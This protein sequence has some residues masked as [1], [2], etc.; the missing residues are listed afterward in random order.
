MVS[1]ETVTHKKTASIAVAGN[2]NCG[3]T[4]LFNGLTGSSQRIGNW[5]GVTVEKKSGTLVGSGEMVEVVDLPGI[6]SLDAVS[7]DERVARDHI[8]DGR[9]DLIVNIIDA[10]NLERNL[11][12]TLTL[13]EMKVPL[14]IVLNMMDVVE[15]RKTVI[16][17]EALSGRLG[18]PV[19]GISALQ[20]SDAARVRVAVERALA[21][22]RVSP[23]DIQYP[24]PVE[25]AIDL[26]SR[27]LAGISADIGIDRR[28]LAIKLLDEDDELID[29]V[30]GAGVLSR[31]EV[32]QAL[33]DLEIS[34]ADTPDVAM[35]EA[36]YHFIKETVDAVR[37]Q[38]DRKASATERID[39]VVMSK[40]LGIPIFLGVI[41]LL[42]WVVTHV[43]GA[44]IDFFDLAVGTIF[45]DGFGALLTS[46]GA[47]VW[48][49]SLLAGGVGAGVQTVATFV[50][51]IFS[52][53]FML[54]LLEDSGYMARAAFVMDRFMR[55]IGLPGKAFVPMLVGFGCTVPA[56]MS[57]RTLENKKDRYL[58]VFMTPF[59]SCG[60]RLPV[61]ALFGAAFFGA[62]SGLVVFSL[63]MIGIVLAI[64]TGLLLKNTLFKGEAAP[65]V[66]ELPPYHAPRMRQILRRTWMRLRVFLLRAGKVIVLAVLFLSFLNSL[67]TDGSFGNEDSTE[68]VLAKISKTITPI[69]TPMGVEK[70]NWPATVGLFTGL[71][72]KEAIVGTISSLYSQM[73]AAE[74]AAADT[75]EE[76]PAERFRLGAG[77]M[78]ALASIPAGLAGIFGALGDPLGAGVIGEDESVIA[79]EVGARA[80]TFSA[81]RRYF[82]NDGAR[83]YAYLLFVLIYF[84]CVA[85]L[86]AILR[87]I[88]PRFGWMAIAYLTIL[89]WSVATLFFQIARGGSV[90]WSVVAVGLVAGF[91]PLLNL[92]TRRGRIE[93][94]ETPS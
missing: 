10:S 38:D 82:D 80:G 61:Y 39:R 4:T 79:E 59:M 43:G 17:V 78:D 73:G 71:F 54:S 62:R 30:V 1:S 91:I 84:P 7:E 67:G 6:Y 48:L 47:P 90:L 46:F 26:W 64:L 57:T 42:F 63:Y 21:D 83:A 81:L 2:P 8:L 12:L 72:A 35:A 24:E 68:S 18:V 92:V 41:Y 36:K 66:M 23:A 14:I 3:K 44:F 94:L 77:L 50:P 53:F 5:P 70:E 32:S 22:P 13:I 19:L 28:L 31:D 11:F 49:V 58:T 87:E 52:M 89:A 40:V 15:K 20:G 69:F 34:L 37:R 29:R 60:A 85:A 56:V 93:V 75:G 45:V 33:E 55:L 51:V 74:A 86:G 25:K 16:D 76:L 88:G 9:P 65:F 27:K